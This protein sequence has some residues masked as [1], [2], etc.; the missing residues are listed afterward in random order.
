M[1]TRS[2]DI[3]VGWGEESGEGGSAV[4]RAVHVDERW[5]VRHED[6]RVSTSFC[7][8]SGREGGVRG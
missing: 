5:A 6:S 4:F 2:G 3:E 1:G 8:L 7:M